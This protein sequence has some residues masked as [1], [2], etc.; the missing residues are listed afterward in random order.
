M[1]KGKGETAF[2]VARVRP[3]TIMFEIGG[4][5]ENVAKQALV[6]VANKM[7]VRCRFVKRRH[8]L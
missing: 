1:G 3:G 4:V 5:E 7:P 6:R 8:L 2:W